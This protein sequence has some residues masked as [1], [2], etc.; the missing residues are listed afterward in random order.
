MKE[1][2]ATLLHSLICITSQNQS[3][4]LTRQ[5]T[6][7]TIARDGLKDAFDCLLRIAHL[8]PV[9][10]EKLAHHNAHWV[11]IVRCDL[12]RVGTC[13]GQL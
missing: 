2:I 8:L 6:S 3:R 1:L 12:C 5:V 4:D 7:H 10:G 9:D 11:I 13:V